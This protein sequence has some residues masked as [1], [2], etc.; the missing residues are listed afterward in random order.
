M[1]PEDG[2]GYLQTTSS[3]RA[4]LRSENRRQFHLRQS[5]DRRKVFGNPVRI[6]TGNRITGFVEHSDYLIVGGGL[7]GGSAA[8]SIREL[9]ESGRVI[10]VTDE[11]HRPYDRVPLSK[12]YL[13]G[14][15]K[16][17]TVYI[18]D[19]DYYENNGIELMTGV[20]AVKL[21]IQKSSVRLNI[22]AEVSFKRLL[23]STGGRVRR[24]SFEGAD[25]RRVFY[26][27]TI[28]DSEAIQKALHEHKRAVV[29]G[30]GFIGCEL[31]S[32][33]ARNGVNTTIVETTDNLL[34]RV[35]DR[36]T[37][38]WIGGYFES[39]GI[40]IMTNTSAKRF[41]GENGAVVGV[42]VANGDRIP[43]DFVTVGIG[44]T[45]NVELARE[46][47]IKVDNGIL[48]DEH[49]ETSVPGIYAA[50]DV[51]NFHSPVFDRNMRLEHYDLAVN[52]G[53]MAGA[54][55]T[56]E[57]RIFNILPYFFSYILDL[58]LEVY[59]DLGHYDSI[60]RRG[61]LEE[62]GFIQFYL[63][64]GAVD[65]VMLVNR[66]EDL[67]TINRLVMSRQRLDNPSILGDES[68][69]LDQLVERNR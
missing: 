32:A 14:K 18:E 45:P 34:G 29:V 44:I 49:L 54:N 66:S 12:D 64:N 7:A 35:L 5:L 6:K 17:E 20:S 39:R 37:A 26:L 41:V 13:L 22:G 25:L 48:V 15:I 1:E 58:K 2:C 4:N 9:D 46:A 51:A 67:E 55:M 42:E 63:Q 16:K 50:G 8:A 53:E 3:A 19:E 36:E 65:A 38:S 27:R 40:R 24:L 56:G 30:G 23:L 57:S 10:L 28:E 21:D 59:G 60:V 47:G 33:F 68:I 52:H 11:V 62:S 69:G 31:A 61:Q 43:A